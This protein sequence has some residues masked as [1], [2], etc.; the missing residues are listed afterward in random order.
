M[1][2]LGHRVGSSRPR[3]APSG[4]RA[5]SSRAMRR[6]ALRIALSA[7]SSPPRSSLRL[8]SPPARRRRRVSLRSSARPLAS[9]RPAIRR[10]F[11]VAPCASRPVVTP[12]RVCS[13]IF[14]TVF[15]TSREASNVYRASTR[16]R[17]EWS[18][19]RER[20]APLVEIACGDFA[21]LRG[22]WKF[23][24]RRGP[25]ARANAWINEPNL[26]PEQI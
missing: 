17:D 16:T 19:L 5:P 6:H 14:R 10:F 21:S 20:R 15:Q 13:R 11:F 4:R 22:I 24:A 12:L 26:A 7:R 25:C 2:T 9:P 23:R 1:A 3:V 18:A 8:A